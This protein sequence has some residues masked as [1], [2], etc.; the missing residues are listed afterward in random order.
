[1]DPES[2]ENSHWHPHIYFFF[3]LTSLIGKNTKRME[4]IGFLVTPS[5][6]QLQ[7]GMTDT[8]KN[9]RS[10]HFMKHWGDTLLAELA[11]VLALHTEN[12]M[13]DP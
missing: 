10:Y 8:M 6:G 9:S 7:S 3:L 5:H 13:F 4:M 1:M 2:V 12:P 11:T